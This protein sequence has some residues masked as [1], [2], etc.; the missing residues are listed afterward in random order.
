MCSLKYGAEGARNKRSCSIKVHAS[1][2]STLSKKHANLLQ[3]VPCLSALSAL[4][5]SAPFPCCASPQLRKE[6]AGHLYVPCFSSCCPVISAWR[7]NRK[8]FS[9][10]YT[11]IQPDDPTAPSGLKIPASIQHCQLVTHLTGKKSHIH[12]LGSL[13]VRRFCLFWLFGT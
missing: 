1:S 10:C 9:V 2:F 13:F 3:K 8:K 5:Q 7:G 6:H 11:G 4:Q 12:G